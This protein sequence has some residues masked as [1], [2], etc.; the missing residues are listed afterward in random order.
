MREMVS[1]WPALVVDGAACSGRCGCPPGEALCTAKAP[2]TA[3]A[4]A[5]GK[6]LLAVVDW[7]GVTLAA[8]AEWLL[9]IGAERALNLDGGGSTTL[10]IGT[11][12]RVGGRVRLPTHLAV[13]AVRHLK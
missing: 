13:K 2:R 7:P 11:R 4:I 1:G 12:A 10:V 9:S 5:R 3:V 6:V 8:L